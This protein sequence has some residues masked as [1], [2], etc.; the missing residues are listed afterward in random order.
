MLESQSDCRD[1]LEFIVIIGTSISAGL[2]RH[3]RT[4]RQLAEDLIV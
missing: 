4:Q 3:D 1:V 2:P